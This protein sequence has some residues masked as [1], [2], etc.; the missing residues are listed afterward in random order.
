ML[1]GVEMTRKLL[2]DALKTHGLE[3]VGRPGEP[4]D[5]ELHEAMG[6]EES[7]EMDEGHIL[8]VMQKGYKLKERLLRPAKVMVS[9]SSKSHLHVKI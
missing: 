5:P 4:F 9:K 3:V 1:M 6:Q 7:A 8:N 2:L